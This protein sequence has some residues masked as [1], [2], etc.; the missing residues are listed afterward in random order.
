MQ[1]YE[2]L[3]KEAQENMGKLSKETPEQMQAF[4]KFK[5]T[6]EK[7]KLDKKTI[8]LIGIACSVMAHCEWCIALHVKEALDLGASKEEILES[9]W[10][11]VL[12]GGGPSLMYSQCVLKAIE[13]LS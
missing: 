2:E 9:A 1:N 4:M 10:T 11:A 8:S 3:L 7:G 13:D 6:T 12:M 5:E